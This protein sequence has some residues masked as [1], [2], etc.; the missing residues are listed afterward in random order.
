[1]PKWRQ[2]VNDSE[3]E[4]TPINSD[5]DDYDDLLAR[6]RRHMLEEQKDRK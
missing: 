5:D 4:S 3:D 1:M 2:V 6:H